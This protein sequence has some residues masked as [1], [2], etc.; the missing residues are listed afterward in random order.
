MEELND[1]APPT[2]GQAAFE[3]AAE[4]LK[5]EGFSADVPEVE[6]QVTGKEW[7]F[8]NECSSAL[9]LLYTCI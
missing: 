5:K 9:P 4:L 8:Y 6:E 3:Q 1:E 2:N 7:L